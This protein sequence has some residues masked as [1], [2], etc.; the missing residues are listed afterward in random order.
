[1]ELIFASYPFKYSLAEPGLSERELRQKGSL[2]VLCFVHTRGTIAKEI[3]GYD[4][5]KPESAYLSV[6]YN[7]NG[8]QRLKHISADTPVYKFYFKHID[9]GNVFLGTKWDADVSWQQALRN[10]LMAFKAELKVD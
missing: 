8:E 10:H 5:T 6:T 9:S 1:M 3:L 2:Y 4:T 7:D